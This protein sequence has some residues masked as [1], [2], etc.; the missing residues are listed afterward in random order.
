MNRVSICL[1]ALMAL[2][3]SLTLVGSGCGKKEETKP[4]SNSGETKPADGVAKPAPVSGKAIKPGDGTIIGTVFF[5]GKMPE[6]MSPG[7]LLETKE[8]VAPA[9]KGE[10]QNCEQKLIVFT[11]DGKMVVDDA[12]VVLKPPTGQSFQPVKSEGEVVIDQPFCAFVPHVVSIKPGQKLLVKNSAKLV[13]DT[14]VKGDGS[15]NETEQGGSIPV[16]GKRSFEISP[17]KEPLTFNCTNHTWMNGIIWAFNHPYSSVT[18]EKGTFKIEKVP[19]G[20]KLKVEAWHEGD[21]WAVSKPRKLLLRRAK[22]RRSISRS[23]GSN[24]AVLYPEGAMHNNLARG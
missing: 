4:P 11:V 21:G 12:L 23:N 16:G 1:F 15:S 22:P 18:G 7:K 9:G 24:L 8:C 2:T 6:C 14:K 19:T 13:H 17:Q 3:L 10:F 5:E 20:V